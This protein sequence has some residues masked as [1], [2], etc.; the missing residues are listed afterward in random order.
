MKPVYK[1]KPMH[2]QLVA[3]V[4]TAIANKTAEPTYV[5]ATAAEFEA[6]IN[7]VDLPQHWKDEQLATG[8]VILV[9]LK[10]IRV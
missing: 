9:G 4:Q 6:L 8:E 1:A 2:D 10:V 5:E 7:E 3:L